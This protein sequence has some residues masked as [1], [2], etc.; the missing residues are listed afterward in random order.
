MQ[1]FDKSIGERLLQCSVLSGYFRMHVPTFMLQQKK[2]KVENI[3]FV[4]SKECD[5]RTLIPAAGGVH[6][7]PEQETHIPSR[8]RT[9]IVLG[10]D[11][12][13]DPRNCGGGVAYARG[14][15]N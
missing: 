3:Y 5:V 12:H 4:D 8:V 15:R 14:P 1:R 13:A 10:R 6:R 7:N 2:T 11:C 9:I